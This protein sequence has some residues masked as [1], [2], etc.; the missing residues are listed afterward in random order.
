M[1]G[2]TLLDIQVTNMPLSNTLSRPYVDTIENIVLAESYLHPSHN[3]Y[4][5]F[6]YP[7]VCRLFYMYCARLTMTA[8]KEGWRENSLSYLLCL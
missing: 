3:F 6:H 4:V 2:S 8:G 7:S 5:V 1:S